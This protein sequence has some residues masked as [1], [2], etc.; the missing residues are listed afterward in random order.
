MKIMV[1]AAGAVGGYFGSIMAKNHDVLLIARGEHLHRIQENGL[2]VKSVT[3]GDFSSQA[4]AVDKPPDHYIPDVILYCVKA[5]HNE[6]AC[7]VITPTI[8][9]QTTIL[10]LQNGIGCGDFLSSHFGKEKVL[11]GAAYIEASRS[12]PG[13]VQEYG[14][15]CRIALGDQSGNLTDRVVRVGNLLKDCNI[16]HRLSEDIMSDIWQKL[17]FIS[18]LSGMSCITRSRLEEVLDNEALSKMTMAVMR[19]TRAAGTASGVVL[20]SDI[21]ETTM[22]ELL[23]HKCELVSSMYLD[24][25]AGRPLEVDVI[26]GAV[27]AIGKRFGVSTPVNDFISTCLSLADKRA[28]NK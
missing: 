12:E 23:K 11:L 28:R 8:G 26:N 19:E 17:V 5:Y 2:R 25:M 20:P 3:S 15:A 7:E 27:S 16:D 1:M 14:G 9:S 6:E 24:L 22:A 21:V 13:V 18:A 4:L 10:S